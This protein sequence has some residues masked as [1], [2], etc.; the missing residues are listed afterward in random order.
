ML[1]SFHERKTLDPVRVPLLP[2]VQSVQDT[3]GNEQRGEK[4][5]MKKNK[6]SN[7]DKN[8]IFPV[9]SKREE[10]NECEQGKA[11]WTKGRQ[12]MGHPDKTGQTRPC[13]V[14]TAPG[15][16]PGQDEDLFNQPFIHKL[17]HKSIIR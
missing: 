15:G 11:D 4:K 10:I 14:L 8:P 7:E 3:L 13:V 2:D 9:V 5:Q 16:E 1:D 12:N 17:L 6:K